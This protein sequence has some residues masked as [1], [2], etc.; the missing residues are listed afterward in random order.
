MEKMEKEALSSDKKLRRALSTWDLLFL[1]LGGIIGS[2]WLFAASGAAT[3][4]GPGAIWAW[5]IGGFIVLIIALVY[6]ELGSMIPRSGAI[7][8]Y[9]QMSHGNFAGFMLGW[10]YFLSAVSV[11]AVEAEA[12]ITYAA[13]YTSKYGIDLVYTK[14]AILNPLGILLAG[15]LMLLFFFV[16]YLGVKTMGRVNTGMTWWK[17]IIPIATILILLVVHFN[18]SNFFLSSGFTP[19]GWSEVF[20]AISVSGIVFSFLGFRQALDYGG[21]AKTPQ[22]SIPIATIASV[23]IG[24]AIYSMLQFV[25]IGQVNWSSLGVTTGNWAGLASTSLYTAPFATLASSA[26]IVLLTYV[27]YADAYISPSGTLN[28]YLGTSQR[29][30]YG[31]GAM[32]YLH[33]I[34][35]KISKKHRVPLIPLI[36]TFLVGL[37]FFAP[38]PSWYEMVGFI[39]SATVFTYIVGGPALMIFRKHASELK[40]P[41]KLGF[42]YIL[43]PASFVGASEIVYWSGWPVVGDLAV[44]IFIGL[45]V[46]AV[47][48]YVFHAP[49][50]F[51]K[52]SIIRGIWVP[53]YIIVLSFLDY[54]GSFGGIAIITFPLDL[55]IVA[56]V[57][58]IFY[59]WATLSGYRTEEIE[60]M[61]SSGTQYV[62]ENEF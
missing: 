47:M 45:A 10:A 57:G 48:V 8:R 37:V 43:A 56:I 38:F 29:T 6:A 13:T 5:L 11:P 44:A 50:K 17:L 1:S 34:S 20:S 42:A 59:I 21:E 49:G 15:L 39:T 19:Y 25:F 51:D 53:V 18:V 26:G 58:I 40:R 9:G 23:L 36:A 3:L 27:L 60:E 16:N 52:H 30:L 22:R 35:I 46:W 2:G 33:S 41:F 7:S 54:I 55:I 14:T 4:A 24:I 31:L 12:V 62:P 61:I 28:V 32:G